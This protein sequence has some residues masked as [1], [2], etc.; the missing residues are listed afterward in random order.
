MPPFRKGKRGG[1]VISKKTQETPSRILPLNMV[2]YTVY[3]LV[4][5]IALPSQEQLYR[6]RASRLFFFYGFLGH[7]G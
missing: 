1:R 6:L 3:Y 4:Y 2:Y 5:Y 7:T